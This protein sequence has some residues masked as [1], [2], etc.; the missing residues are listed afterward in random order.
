MDQTRHK[1]CDGES[2]DFLASEAARKNKKNLKNKQTKKRNEIILN[3]QKPN[4]ISCHY[5]CARISVCVN[6]DK[7]VAL[8]LK[9]E[10]G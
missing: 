5:V 8:Q 3:E 1:V 4:C 10:V 7:K 2:T 9:K 6:K